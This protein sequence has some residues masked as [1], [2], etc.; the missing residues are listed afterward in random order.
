MF[1]CQWFGS[2]HYESRHYD[3]RH[4]DSQHYDSQHY[5]SR[6]YDI[7]HFN[8]APKK[9]RFQHLATAGSSCWAVT[10]TAGFAHRPKN[11]YEIK[12]RK[13]YESLQQSMEQPDDTYVIEQG[14]FQFPLI[15]LTSLHVIIKP[16]PKLDI[17]HVYLG[18]CSPYPEIS[19]KLLRPEVQK[20]ICSVCRP[21]HN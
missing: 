18:K 14:S 2:R 8:A 19:K 13:A 15:S 6:H 9:P 5:D 11:V 4:Y 20:T 3:S 1:W 7:R 21:F 12:R 17:F 10:G 16:V